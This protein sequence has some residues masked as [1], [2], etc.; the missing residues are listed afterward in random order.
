MCLALGISIKVWPAFFLP[1]LVVRREWKAV[2]WTVVL[3]LLFALLPS[4]YF[5]FSENL[6]LLGQWFGQ[7]FRTQLSESEIWFP[8]QSLRGTL[9]RYLT[10]I[11]YSQVPDSNYA[12]VNVASLDP[13]VVRALWL[14]LSGTIYAGFLLVAQRRRDTDG[15][16]DHALA[17]SLLPLLEPFTQK[18]AMAILLWPAI[19]AALLLT[20]SRLRL[21]VYAATIFAL[22]QPLTPGATAQRFMQ[23]LGFDFMATL[24]LAIALTVACMTKIGSDIT[25][26]PAGAFDKAPD[27]RQ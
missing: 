8:N 5:G 26:H 6:D 7:E 3:V 21:L 19:A 15:W 14:M 20:Q 2:G 17:F 1:Y 13:A 12:A 16:M 25:V 24:L 22:I 18:Y 4:V 9:M 27:L 10:V 23:V 11:D